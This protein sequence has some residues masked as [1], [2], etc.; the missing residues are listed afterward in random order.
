M[1]KIKTLDVVKK[2]KPMGL[3]LAVAIILGI[4]LINLNSKISRLET[5]ISN[6]KGNYYNKNGY[7]EVEI[8]NNRVNLLEDSIGGIKDETCLRLTRLFDLQGKLYICPSELR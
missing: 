3:V 6:I 8:L 7:S 5:R 2:F 1:L 4:V